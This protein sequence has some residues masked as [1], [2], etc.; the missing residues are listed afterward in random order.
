LKEVV[1]DI[2]RLAANDFTAIGGDPVREHRTWLRRVD[3]TNLT[4]EFPDPRYGGRGVREAN[5]QHQETDP[6]GE[7]HHVDP[8]QLKRYEAAPA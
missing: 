3:K 2:S 6:L 1:D 8:A 5:H 7:E 4:V